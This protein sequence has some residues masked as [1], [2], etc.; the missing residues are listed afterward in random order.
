M[1]TTFTAA[2][3]RLLAKMGMAMPDGSY[4]I[5]NV[6]DLTNAVKDFNRSGGSAAEKAWIIKRAHDLNAISALP[7][8]WGVTK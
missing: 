2:Y 4:P 7:K 1:A 6:T 3:R 8:S 5:R